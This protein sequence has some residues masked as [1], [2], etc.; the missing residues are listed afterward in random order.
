[1]SHIRIEETGDI[2]GPRTRIFFIASDGTETDISSVTTSVAYSGKVGEAN[3]ATLDLIC[4]RGDVTTPLV[5]V[6]LR[7]FKPK[8]R[9]WRRRLADVTHMG[10][11]CREYIR[12]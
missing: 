7:E 4:V 9:R 1:M 6:V 3:K 8:R 5:E 11:R 2:A 12:S 10:T